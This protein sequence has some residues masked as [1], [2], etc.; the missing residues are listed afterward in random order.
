MVLNNKFGNII[1]DIKNINEALLATKYN[2]TSIMLY[3]IVPVEIIDMNISGPQFQLKIVNEIQNN[4]RIQ[5]GEE[6]V[7]NH[8]CSQLFGLFN[9][10]YIY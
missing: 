2:A 9:Y 8:K 4:Y 6:K 5:K 1:I 3:D 10:Q 7:Y